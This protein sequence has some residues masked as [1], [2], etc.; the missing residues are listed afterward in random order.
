MTCGQ[1]IK[2]E[3]EKRHMSQENLAEKLEV[4]RQA[5]SKWEAD[6]A[7]PTLE[8]RERLSQLFDLPMEVWEDPP[9]PEQV[10]LRRWKI[11]AAALGAALCL[12]LIFGAALWPRG[13]NVEHLPSEDAQGPVSEEPPAEAIPETLTLECRR[14]YDF[15]N[16][17]LGTYDPDLSPLLK[18]P[19][20]IQNHCR[21][22][23]TFEQ[24]G[25]ALE[26]VWAD[27]ME[28]DGDTYY[29]VYLLY[30]IPAADGTCARQISC[31]L[32]EELSEEDL[33]AGLTVES[34][35]QVAGYDGYR[36]G[37]DMGTMGI[38]TY[39]F[40][41]GPDGV[42]RMMTATVG[43]GPM[44]FDVD[45]DGQMEII[46]PESYSEVIQIID[47]TEDGE[48]GL[49]YSFDPQAHGNTGLRI[50][51][52]M[53]GFVLTDTR[54]AVLARYVLR[55]GALVRLPITDFSALDY[56]DVAG[57]EITFVTD[58]GILSD[59]REPDEVLYAA[60]GVCV[61]HRQQA[62]LALQELYNLTGLTV[63]SCYCAA[64]EYGVVFSLLPDGFNQRSFYSMDFSERC[65]GSG[66]PGL[67]I[68]WR[69]LGNDWS[70][71]SFAEAVHPE[72]WLAESELLRWYYER[73]DLFSTGEA[74]YAN[75]DE[76]YLTNGDS[77][78]AVFQETG[79]GKALTSLHGPYPG[80]VINH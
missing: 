4:S 21:W 43:R 69:E 39:F 1:R 18:D 71:L 20:W 80:G 37:L 77:Y 41:P 24:G 16:W 34:F 75:L 26:L 70:P 38:W 44:A 2:R 17:A 12:T 10:S 6:A 47:S 42:P 45:E 65:G 74:A 54:N 62:Y 50:D 7:R 57:T 27:P 25:T 58:F 36:I 9:A 35:S 73:L 14:D 5:V 31:R 53:G 61:T 67:Y 66:I 55:D 8:K 33:A 48:G 22:V 79:Q 51:P 59:G 60:E 29:N 63:D 15:G 32:A 52:E 13:E 19:E 11:T 56:P 28:K 76:L 30:A 78:L 72:S 3:R 64:N 46:S 23:G 40:V 49:V 68:A